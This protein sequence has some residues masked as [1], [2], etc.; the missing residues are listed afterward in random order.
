MQADIITILRD[1]ASNYVDRLADSV[2]MKRLRKS[3]HQ[4]LEKQKG[5]AYVGMVIKVAV[6]IWIGWRTW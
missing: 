2:Q 5:Y 6:A 4:P 1:G 3:E